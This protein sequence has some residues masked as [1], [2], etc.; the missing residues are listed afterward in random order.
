[1]H[2]L[3]ATAELAPIAQVG[4]LG[5]AA[6]GLV[7]ALRE[8]GV[9]VTVAMPDYGGVELSREETV[10][11]D[12]PEWAGPAVARTGEHAQ[13][14]PVTLINAFG[15]E[16]PHPYLQPDGE[17]WPD[18]DRRFF[19]FSTAV[20]DLVRRLAPDVL[21]LN[22][23]HTALTLAFPER[24]PPTVFTI[25][26][27]AYQGRTNDGWL[28]GLPHRRA[29]FQRDG[30]CNPLVGAVRLADL[31]VAVSPTYAQE[32][33]TEVGGMGVDDELRSRGHRVVGIRN[34][35]DADIWD[36]QH[37]AD[38]PEPYGWPDVDGKAV[39]A[40]TVRAEVG[41]PDDDTALV[42]M[43]SRLAEQKGVD[44][45]L[46][47]L[48][49][50]GGL[51]A[52]LAL[53]GDGD[54]RLADALGAA[55]VHDPARFAFRQGFDDRLAHLLFAGGDLLVMPSRFE[56]CG[57]AQMQ[58]MRYGTIPVVTDVGGLH[59]T[60]VD[61]D[62]HPDDGTGI[63]ARTPSAVALVDALHRGVRAHASKVQRLALQRRGMT[64]DWS[65]REPAQEHLQHY[66]QLTTAGGSP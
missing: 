40:R 56:P 13:A 24:L 48:D 25:H 14:G 32:I 15:S 16:R 26:N 18:N 39:A 30:D 51:P 36:P 45:L 34:G 61:V 59:D 64:A 66:R 55:A 43:V 9:D 20:A 31:V 2:V 8:L 3:F 57:L 49:L 10:A 60:V 65:W 63:V 29:A 46:P 37:D 28:A 41:L 58:A 21:H 17:G 50:L 27:L 4:G 12:V 52:Q 33:V 53:L 7:D 35:I 5:I 42:V 44:L 54:Q 6:S 1:M 11:L 19:A 38:I 23:W 22:D 47:V 62:A